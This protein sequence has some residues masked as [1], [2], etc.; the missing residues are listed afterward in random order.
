MNHVSIALWDESAF[1]LY[2]S[3]SASA[4]SPDEVDDIAAQLRAIVKEVT[5][6][7]VEQPEKPRM[8][9]LP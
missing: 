8:G 2:M 7:D 9:F 1:S 6:K 3:G 4:S 5:G